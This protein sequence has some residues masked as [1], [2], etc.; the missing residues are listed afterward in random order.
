MTVSRSSTRSRKKTD[1]IF[2]MATLVHISAAITIQSGFI[3]MLH[4]HFTSC[5]HVLVVLLFYCINSVSGWFLQVKVQANKLERQLV[6]CW[7]AS[8]L[9]LTSRFGLVAVFNQ[10]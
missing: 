7:S 3:Q 4:Q 1:F 10:K 8:H 9:F 2:D 5:S 6:G